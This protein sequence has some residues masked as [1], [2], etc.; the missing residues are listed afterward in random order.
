VIDRGKETAIVRY[1]STTGIG[2]RLF[3]T[4]AAPAPVAGGGAGGGAGSGRPPQPLRVDDLLSSPSVAPH[5]R[6]PASGGSA[7][8]SG[9][10]A[11]PSPHA[12]R[13][14]MLR[15]EEFIAG[16]T[17]GVE[18]L[19][20]D[21]GG[22]LGA[23]MARKLARLHAQRPD[24]RQR[25]AE[26]RARTG[27]SASVHALA[28]AEPVPP[29]ELGSS[30]R[31]YLALLGDIVSHPLVRARYVGGGGG[32]AGGGG[33]PG[34]PRAL[35]ALVLDELPDWH[36]EVAWLV[37]V[38]GAHGGPS[39]LTHGDAQEGNWLLAVEEGGAGAGAGTGTGGA[40]DG[41][42]LIDYEY[43]RYDHRGF[44]GGNL[45]CEHAFDYAVPTHPGFGFAPHAYP[46]P[47]WQRAY[48]AA[49]AAEAAALAEAARR[50]AA[51][52]EGAHDV[53]AA[54]AGGAPAGGTIACGGDADADATLWARTTC[55]AEELE[56]QFGGDATAVRLAGEARLGAL[57]SHLYWALWSAIM[58]AGKAGL[59]ALAAGEAATAAGGA[60]RST[61]PDEGVP[62]L[63]TLER[64]ASDTAAAVAGVAS[65][66]S[67]FDY[68]VYGVERARE[69]ARLK[70]QLHA[71][72]PEWC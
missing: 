57:A 39:V 71:D 4:Y 36:G 37:R 30:L 63:A 59:V 2:P 46:A 69:F 50:E 11:Q 34:V 60:A 42:K 19:R 21:A 10:D 68:A 56:R 67:V 32:A 41:L 44:D 54:D 62:P 38:M 33:P 1:L 48:F 47:S 72:R 66:H 35:L 12:P 28:R 25:A 70:A 9:T 3:G 26:A 45:L 22:R 51:A 16:R 15:F 27:S 6:S 13:T 52:D 55:A 40:D 31:R 24:L 18:D 5:H 58:A 8:I 53:T 7:G 43:A 14:V 61:A 64:L 49:Y 23:R 65:G 29:A 17:L 20:Q